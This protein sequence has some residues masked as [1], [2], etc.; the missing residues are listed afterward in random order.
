[1]RVWPLRLSWLL[2]LRG[3]PWTSTQQNHH[4]AVFHSGP[5]QYITCTLGSRHLQRPKTLL[6]L[7]CQGEATGA[8]LGYR[9]RGHQ[10]TGQSQRMPCLI[11]SQS[12]VA[13]H[14]RT[15]LRD[16]QTKESACPM[17]PE[18]SSL[19]RPTPTEESRPK[20]VAVVLA[21]ALC[22][23]C[24]NLGLEHPAANHLVRHL[25]MTRDTR[26]KWKSSCRRCH[27]DSP[28]PKQAMDSGLVKWTVARRYPVAVRHSFPTG[29]QRQNPYS[30]LST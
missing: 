24:I 1:M 28:S 5:T 3:I 7:G 11:T 14:N 17:T 4:L 15:R 9:R 2:L 30:Q 26:G 22:Q 8:T 13:E 12:S 18:H 16:M 21:Q 29:R 19:A 27:L 6:A 10:C 20:M 23:T 25:T